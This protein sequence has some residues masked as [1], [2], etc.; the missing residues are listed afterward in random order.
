MR[1]FFIFLI[2]LLA[3]LAAFFYFGPATLVTMALQEA[4]SR[5]TQSDVKVS[6]VEVDLGDGSASIS[7]LSIANPEGFSSATAL[8]LD[9]ISVKLNKEQSSLQTIVISSVLIDAPTVR[10]ELKADGASNIGRIQR[11]IDA[12]TGGKKGGAGSGGGGSGPKI[13]VDRLEI[14]SGTITAVAPGDKSLDVKLPAITM[15]DLGRR[16]GGVSAGE[17]AAAVLDEVSET[18]LTSVAKAQ[19]L[20]RLGVGGLGDAAKGIGDS[21]KGLF[22]N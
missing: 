15:T 10:Y 20:D 2:F 11:N 3:L 21:V 4:G 9:D 5:A 8:G 6:G 1:A 12:F 16:E 22:G 19:I 7:G 18:T 13:I 14:R 17:I